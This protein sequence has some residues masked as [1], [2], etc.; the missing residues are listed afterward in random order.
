M[1]PNTCYPVTGLGG[2]EDDLLRC[3]AQLRM[4][5]RLLADARTSG[6]LP[7]QVLYQGSVA[8][9]IAECNRLSA[10][11]TAKEMPTDFSFGV[12]DIGLKVAALL[13]N[14]GIAGAVGLGVI[15]YLALRRR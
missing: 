3:Q 13:R 7:M 2:A 9:L 15:G 5:A 14:L 1:I 10:K 8:A 12:A 11:L 4:V 6:N